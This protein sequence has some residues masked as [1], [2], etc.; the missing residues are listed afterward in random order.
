MAAWGGIAKKIK[1]RQGKRCAS[2][3]PGARTG[4]WEAPPTRSLEGCATQRT[5]PACRFW[6]LPSHQFGGRPAAKGYV[7]PSVDM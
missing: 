3:S 1:S 4:G 7:P 5:L 2:D 6:R